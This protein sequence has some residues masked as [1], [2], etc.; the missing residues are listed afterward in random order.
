[1]EVKMRVQ[2]PKNMKLL[3]DQNVCVSYISRL[4]GI[5]FVF[6]TIKRS[7][8]HSAVVQFPDAVVFE[9]TIRFIPVLR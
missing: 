7:C 2:G 8:V 1:M 6:L 5:F 4:S 9:A 3:P